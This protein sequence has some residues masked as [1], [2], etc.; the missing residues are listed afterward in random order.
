MSSTDITRIEHDIASLDATRKAAHLAAAT[1]A[2]QNTAAAKDASEL[3]LAL[4]ARQ[5]QA[6]QTLSALQTAS[7]GVDASPHPRLIGYGA[8][9][10]YMVT[11]ESMTSQWGSVTAAEF[12]Y[13]L[14]ALLSGLERGY[15]NSNELARQYSYWHEIPQLMD[16]Q[17]DHYGFI[18]KPAGHTDDYASLA[19]YSPVYF[20]YTVLQNTSDVDLQRN[21]SMYATSGPNSSHTAAV[22]TALIPNDANSNGFDFKLISSYTGFSIRSHTGSLVIPAG[23]RAIIFWLCGSYHHYRTDVMQMTTIFS[24]YNLDALFQDGSG[25]GVICDSGMVLNLMPHK[26]WRFSDLSGVLSYNSLAPAADDNS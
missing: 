16:I 23:K 3:A 14:F 22:I 4:S 8:K 2:A 26:S 9:A 6:Q 18:A 15:N 11:G 21:F 13:N 7:G 12:T 25:P 1:H 24:L 10:R 19:S 5:A 20:A 17:R